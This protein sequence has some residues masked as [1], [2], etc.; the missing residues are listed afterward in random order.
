[1][2]KYK[3]KRYY[4]YCFNFESDDGECISACDSDIYKVSIHSE[5]TL[6]EIKLEFVNEGIEIFNK[7]NKLI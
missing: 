5:M 4:K 1:M 6:E 3:F 7:E 2:K